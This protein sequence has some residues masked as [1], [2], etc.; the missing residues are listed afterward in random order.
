MKKWFKFTM[1]IV[2][3]MAFIVFGM[4]QQV[5]ATEYPIEVEHFSGK[6][7]LEKEPERIVVFDYAALDTL[8][9]LG[10]SDKIVGVV[11]GNLPETLAKYKEVQTIGSSKEPN[12]EAIASL[13]PDLVVVGNRQSDSY[14]EFSKLWPT[15]DATVTWANIDADHKYTDNVTQAITMLSQAVNREA[16]GTALVEA[17]TKK[18]ADYQGKGKGT[19][20]ALMSSGGEVAMQ[21]SYSR[22]APIYEVF[23]FEPMTDEKPSEGHKGDKISFE[24]IQTMNPDWIFVLDRDKA[25]NSDESAQPAQEV[26]DNPLVQETT[27]YK[28]DQIVYLSPAEWYLIMTGAN[29][30]QHILDEIDAII[31]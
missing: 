12:L 23:G 26:L 18:V 19:A 10:V 7:T 30:Y 15:I 2:M 16:E 31:K 13:E 8:D 20:M 6:L 9:A 4:G 3:A 28:N 22:F 11:Q 1:S 25:I 21:S 17:I 27:A 29:N 14:E 24:T 5:A